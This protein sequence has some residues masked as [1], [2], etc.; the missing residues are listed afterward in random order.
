MNLRELEGNFL[1][2]E[3]DRSFRTV[4]SIGAANGVMFK[5]PVCFIENGGPQGTHHVICWSPE[6]PQ[7]VRPKPG[8]WQLIGTSIDDL[9][10]VAGSSSVALQGGCAAH[11]FV[12]NGQIRM[13]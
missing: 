9:S 5:C 6:V 4:D 3:D 1:F 13:A 12:E 2:C 11:F 7:T 10:L 8:R